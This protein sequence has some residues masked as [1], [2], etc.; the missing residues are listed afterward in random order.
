[1]IPGALGGTPGHSRQA[2]WANPSCR[3]FR[4][5][6]NLS[7]FLAGVHR[8]SINRADRMKILKTPRFSGFAMGVLSHQV[9]DLMGY[10]PVNWLYPL[11]GLF[12]KHL[13][14]NIL[15][16]SSRQ[17]RILCLKCW[18]RVFSESECQF[19]WNS[20]GEYLLWWNPQQRETVRICACYRQSFCQRSLWS[21][22]GIFL[23]WARRWTLFSGQRIC[24]Q[25]VV[26]MDK[27]CFWIVEPFPDN[28][29]P[30]KSHSSSSELG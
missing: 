4:I 28:K 17:N 15:L 21:E 8:D 7:A 13:P 23:L 16:Y 12:Q 9:I 10:E 14:H 18:L 26:V 3:L 11:P 1:M 25:R 24:F 5:W 20:M 30:W 27:C 29:Y 6:T 2:A 19:I 22:S